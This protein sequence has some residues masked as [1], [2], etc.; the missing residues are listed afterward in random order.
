MPRCLALHAAD[1]GTIS[2]HRE[3]YARIAS[4]CVHATPACMRDLLLAYKCMHACMHEI[5]R[6]ALVTYCVVSLC[7][8]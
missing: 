2:R 4:A 3:L 5:G 1:Q 7:I 8:A 6:P